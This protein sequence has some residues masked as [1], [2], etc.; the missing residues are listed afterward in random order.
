MEARIFCFV[1]SVD[2]QTFFRVT[3]RVFRLHCHR[4]RVEQWEFNQSQ[5]DYRRRADAAKEGALGGW[6]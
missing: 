3:V 1:E 6:Q 4:V 5:S 2:G